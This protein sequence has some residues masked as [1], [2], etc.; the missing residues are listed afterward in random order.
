MHFHTDASHNYG[1]GGGGD[2]KWCFGH[3]T[4][5]ELSSLCMSAKKLFPIALA[6]ST[7]PFRVR[8]GVSIS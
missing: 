4:T 8:T 6:A 2:N 5:E 3:W 1:F 7:L